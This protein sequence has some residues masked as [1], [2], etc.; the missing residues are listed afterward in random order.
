MPPEICANLVGYNVYNLMRLFST[1]RIAAVR[2]WGTILATIQLT[3][4]ILTLIPYT[5]LIR[6]EP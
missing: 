5:T 1:V 4:A 6:Q 2:H 3:N